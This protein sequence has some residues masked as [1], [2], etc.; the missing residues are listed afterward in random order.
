M[1]T[2]DP[3]VV[4]AAAAAVLQFVAEGCS[5]AEPSAAPGLAAAPPAGLPSL[6]G[7]A[8][9]QGGMLERVAWQRRIS[10]SW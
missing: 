6:W 3:K 1:G 10:R 4:A 5:P 9:R 8:G 7:W 2:V